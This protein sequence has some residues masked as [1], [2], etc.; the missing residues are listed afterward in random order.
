MSQTRYN[1]ESNDVPFKS[2]LEPDVISI[3]NRALSSGNSQHTTSYKYAFF[4]S[5]L[6]NVF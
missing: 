5:I 4:K 2:L 1:S 3:V 6:D